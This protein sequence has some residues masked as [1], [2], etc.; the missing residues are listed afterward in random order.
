MTHTIRIIL[1][2]C[3]QYEK[4]KSKQIITRWIPVTPP[5]PEPNTIGSDM[6]WLT[7]TDTTH[8]LKNEK[9]NRR[10][11][12]DLPSLANRYQKNEKN[13][14]KENTTDNNNFPTNVAKDHNITLGKEIMP[15]VIMKNP[16]DEKSKKRKTRILC[17]FLHDDHRQNR[18]QSTPT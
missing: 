10:T 18:M 14:L 16:N 2:D 7:I 1:H 17:D 6:I 11:V 12:F 13:A 9:R 3:I 15:I 8:V 5:P 4:T